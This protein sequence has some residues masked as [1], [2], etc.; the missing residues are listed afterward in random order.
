[1]HFFDY[2]RVE[3]VLSQHL[4]FVWI[5]GRVKN[6]PNHQTLKCDLDFIRSAFALGTVG[7]AL[8]D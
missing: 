5:V 2:W 3:L 7:H 6:I 1:M 4:H 8:K